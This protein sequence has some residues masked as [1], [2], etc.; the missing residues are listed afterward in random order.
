MTST[1]YETSVDVESSTEATPPAPVIPTPPANAVSYDLPKDPVI[2]IRPSSTWSALDLGSLWSYRELLVFLIWRDIKVRYKQ[3]ILGATWA[4]IQPLVMMIVFTFFFSKLARI[5]TENI[6]SA[7]FYYT[8]LTAWIFFSNAALTAANSLLGNTNLITKVYFPRL[9][10]P[11]AAVGASL[12]DLAIASALLIA[13]LFYY[14]FGVTLETLALIPLSMILTA[15]AL[16]VG[17]LFSALN[18]KYRDVRYAL[19]FILQVWM[20]VS[21]VIY[22]ISMVPAEWRWVLILNPMTGV[23]EG[24]RS[25]LFGRPLNVWAIT[26]SAAFAAILLLIS[27]YAFK[28]MEKSF[29]EVI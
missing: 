6:P 15:L 1:S 21:P 12:V 18:T 13:L 11:S 3:T 24:F 14:G 16:A 10:I 19:P 17:I 28:R 26:H 7:A 23:I 29:A 4:V 27:A 25:S 2:T 9:I 20:F 8:G 22:P 5:P